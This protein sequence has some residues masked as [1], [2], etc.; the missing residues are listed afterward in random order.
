MSKLVLTLFALLFWIINPNVLAMPSDM[1][2][3]TALI[4]KHNVSLYATMP[5]KKEVYL[6][7]FHL[8]PKQKIKLMNKIL[9]N[10]EP[11]IKD[12][13][14]PSAVDLGMNGVPVLDQGKHG[15][16]VT[17]AVTAAVDAL[18]GKGDYISQLCNLELSDYLS[19]Q[20]NINYGWNDGRGGL[21]LNQML[22][23][24]II[25]KETQQTKSCA[26]V[27][28]YPLSD[29][30]N[31]GNPISLA[32]F[33]SM[34]ENIYSRLEWIPILTF[35]Q[36]ME[37]DPIHS[38]H[39]NKIIH[40]IKKSL[41]AAKNRKDNQLRFTFASWLPVKYCSAGACA[42]HHAADDTWALTQE[43]LNDSSSWHI[44]G[45][46]M[47]ITGYD[48]NASAVDKDG[49]TH[50]GL[51]ILRNSW[52][53]EVGDNGNYYMTYDFFKKFVIEVQEIIMD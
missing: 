26:G 3:S 34:N 13:R 53:N 39:P 35:A 14:L 15:T 45:H 27:K 23:F 4:T 31:T 25:N 7:N 43:I 12:L 50:R 1:V 16:C 21:V 52:G 29:P 42:S 44:A 19:Q 32:E 48:D 40:Q 33:K 6:M 30:Y 37:E 2:V 38:Y 18:L 24:G 10:D 22:Q 51:F 5:A 9:S 17:F 41:V 28:E 8:T 11:F 20:G 36:S 46:Q 49:V 47:I